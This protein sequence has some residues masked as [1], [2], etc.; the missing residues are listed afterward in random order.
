MVFYCRAFSKVDRTKV[1]IQ[2]VI[3]AEGERSPGVDKS[4]RRFNTGMVMVVQH[5][6]KPSS[7]LIERTT[8][9]RKQW[10][11][12]FSVTTGRRASMTADPD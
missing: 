8:G 9:I 6:A 11:D 2:D 12:Y 1:T 3:A 5:R 4:Q 7:E 10:I